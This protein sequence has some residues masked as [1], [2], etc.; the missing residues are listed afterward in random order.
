MDSQ[1]P[2]RLLDV[3]EPAEHA[4]AALPLARLI[5]LRELPE[6]LPEI[7][8]WHRDDTVVY[9]HHGIRSAQAVAW[10]ASIGFVRPLNLI[11][12]IDEWSRVIDLDLP[13]Y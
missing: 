6:R 3:R 1:R 9:C 8:D 7:R 13:R 10:L 2:F 4:M 12:G 11:G 5:P